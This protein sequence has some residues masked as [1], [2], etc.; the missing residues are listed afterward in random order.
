[1]RFARLPTSAPILLSLLICLTACETAP[2]V[3]TQYETVERIVEVPAEINPDLTRP[4]TRCD[5]NSISTWGDALKMAAVCRSEVLAANCRFL[6]LEKKER[7]D[8]CL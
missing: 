6:E 4:L 1:M 2:K 8:N 3:V 7:P 5:L